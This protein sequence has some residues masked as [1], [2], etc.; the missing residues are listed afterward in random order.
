MAGSNATP[1][2]S[3]LHENYAPKGSSRRSSKTSSELTQGVQA[4]RHQWL[5]WR[6]A[7][8]NDSGNSLC[9]LCFQIFGSGCCMRMASRWR[10]GLCGLGTSIGL[11]LSWLLELL[12]ECGSYLE[13]VQQRLWAICLISW[14]AF[15][16]SYFLQMED[17][18][19]QLGKTGSL[20]N[21]G[22]QLFGLPQHAVGAK[23]PC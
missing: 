2:R 20:C 17:F 10:A 15:P 6:H 9:D 8:T 1:L 22:I 3:V 23:S 14:S 21:F 12:I 13:P 16:V 4:S 19:H 7:C 11:K 18:C 5:I